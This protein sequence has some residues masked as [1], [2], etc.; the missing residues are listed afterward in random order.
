MS[1]NYYSEIH[2]L[3][4]WHTKTS[5]PILTPTIE[6]LA[7]RAIKHKIVDWPGA[8]V[9]EIGGT[10][11]HVHLVVTIAPTITISEFIGQIKG[12][13]SHDVN[14]QAGRGQR[15]LEW[16][17]GYGVVSFGTKDMPW[18]RE[19][20]RNQREH[21]AKDRVYDRLERITQI[22]DGAEA[23]QPEAP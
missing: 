20:V 17:P 16:Q 9:H 4:T 19:Y 15:V 23:E 1:R 2:L 6:P 8:F 21:H 7:H 11:T 13:S 5:S 22:E 12:A 3:L 10:E 14:Q 18:V